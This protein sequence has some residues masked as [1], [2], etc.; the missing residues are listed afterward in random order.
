MNLD[1]VRK[2]IQEQFERAHKLHATRPRT[3]ATKHVEPEATLGDRAAPIL[4][5]IASSSDHHRR[6]CV[7]YEIIEPNVSDLD[8]LFEEALASLGFKTEMTR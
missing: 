3:E 7:S 2:H 5:R 1:A 8:A 6:D 4:R